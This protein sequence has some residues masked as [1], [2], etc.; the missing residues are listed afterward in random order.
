[1]SPVTRGI[2]TS[3]A[4][5]DAQAASSGNK[6]GSSLAS[7]G[8]GA[9]A[10]GM[11]GIGGFLAVGAAIK[12]TTKAAGD[13]DYQLNLLQTHANMPTD[14]AY[15]AKMRQGLMDMA[16]YGIDATTAAEGM[17]YVQSA[18]IHDVTQALAVETAAI[19]TAQMTHAPLNDTVYSLVTTMNALPG[20]FKSSAE[21]AA[22][23][24]GIVGSGIMTFNDLNLALKSGVLGTGD[25]AGSNLKEMGAM[26]D[27]LTQR[28]FSASSAAQQVRNLFLQIANTHPDS[29]TDLWLK[30]MGINQQQLAKDMVTP[31]KGI[32][33]ALNE[34]KNSMNNLPKETQLQVLDKLFRGVKGA[35]QTAVML[36]A[37]SDVPTAIA[38]MNRSADNW[39]SNWAKTAG[40]SVVQTDIFTASIHNAKIAF[41]QAL[42]PMVIQFLGWITPLVDRLRGWA[43]SHQK[44]IATI[45]PMIMQFF[46]LMAVVGG[47]VFLLGKLQMMF[48]AAGLVMLGIGAVAAWLSSHWGALAKAFQPV[49]DAVKAVW[50]AFQSLQ[51]AK[52]IG[53]TVSAAMGGL[54]GVSAG[55][56]AAFTGLGM[57]IAGF[58]RDHGLVIIGVI[59]DIFDIAKRF[60]GWVIGT[61]IPDV[62]DALVKAVQFL[63]QWFV[64]YLL[65]TLENLVR[66]FEGPGG[67]A[68]KK[69]AQSILDALPAIGR[70][71]IGL[72]VL[73]GWL[74]DH[75][76]RYLLQLAE[77][78]VPPLLTALAWLQDHFHVV[79]TFA[80]ALVVALVALVVINVASWALSAYG[81]V[82]MLAR[83]FIALNAGEALGG[84]VG[85]L[86]GL[87]TGIIRMIPGGAGLLAG[88]GVGAAEGTV[89]GAAGTA[90]TVAEK[91]A[92][93]GAITAQ[94]VA[95]EAAL[96]AQTEALCL[97]CGAGRVAGA[98]AEGA[99]GAGTGI[100]AGAAG[101]AGAG[102]GAAAAIGGAGVSS[103]GAGGAE[104][105]IGTAIAGAGDLAAAAAVPIAATATGIGGLA[106]A[107]LGLP[108]W[109][110]VGIVVAIGAAVFALVH[111]W[112]QVTGA[113]GRFYRF[114]EDTAGSWTGQVHGLLT[115]VKNF[116]GDWL[117][118]VHGVITNTKNFLGDWAGQVHGVVTNTK[119]FLGDM[120]GDIGGFFEAI[121]G[122]VLGVIRKIP[123]AFDAAAKQVA[124]DFGSWA[125]TAA[126]F[127]ADLPKDAKRALDWTSSELNSWGGQI[128]GFWTNAG[129]QIGSWSGNFKGFF[130]SIPGWMGS[131]GSSIGSQTASWAGDF[132]RL[133]TAASG[134]WDR[135]TTSVD[136]FITNTAGR[137]AGWVGRVGGDIGGWITGLASAFNR[138]PGLWDSATTSIEN[139][140]RSLLGAMGGFFA[141]M[142][143]RIASAFS[144][145]KTWLYN[146]GK[147]IITGLWDGIR[148]MGSRLFGWLGGLK[149]SIVRG[150]NDHFRSGSPSQV[151]AE[152]M[153]LPITQGIALGIMNGRGLVTDALARVVPTS[154]LQGPTLVSSAATTPTTAS[155]QLATQNDL[156]Q[157]IRDHL[158]ALVTSAT[159]PGSADSQHQV[160]TTSTGLEG[161]VYDLI[162]QVTTTRKR[163]IRGSYL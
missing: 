153:G 138:I 159:G 82:A 85:L 144:G 127:F 65:P 56:I 89:A 57:A 81:A 145:A 36:Q 9:A 154:P 130:E 5:L 139:G 51:G 134:G 122:K 132:S 73:A 109:A 60:T 76:G 80:V 70:L 17:Y 86:K 156:L 133:T 22:V 114:L 59:Y 120:A 45:T 4:E 155:A 26:M 117:G 19:Q 21:A 93:T 157:Q 141:D 67:S 10:A 94:T 55:I 64:I 163:G 39:A 136:T 62:W 118:Q 152:Q 31:G 148:S 151:A 74:W 105:A 146:A 13:F 108:L 92:I 131:A 69:F 41:G 37:L 43:E 112:D 96:L 2:G 84:T 124:Y 95:L 147:D 110:I 121:P 137:F 46:A 7:V 158:A 23:L 125:G 40:L 20:Q 77:E 97:C 75:V 126:S 160:R 34:F 16:K 66:W 135:L 143:G 111:Y 32:L 11:V 83:A 29:K 27:T 102:A 38:D 128:G 24:N 107:I 99:V 14:P 49:I 50:A 52:G 162:Q 161:K 54:G 3:L 115:N 119:N 30:T 47:G 142:P 149:D 53:G 71:V 15:I 91:V 150:F 103:I 33:Y 87:G 129:N 113:V 104:I 8:S 90:G 98:V 12:D 6:A 1:V 68:L 61:F 100:A 72:M 25:I 101:G 58:I 48:S 79:E 63:V 106:A 44:L 116:L 42:I 35:G 88:A 18:G 28:G 78:V 140:A 123:D